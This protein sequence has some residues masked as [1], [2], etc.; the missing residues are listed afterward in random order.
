MS[1]E[2]AALPDTFLGPIPSTYFPNIEDPGEEEELLPVGPTKLQNRV[3]RL[4]Y[5]A[6]AAELQGQVLHQQM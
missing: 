4:G 1:S 6:P 5:S 3:I 2:H